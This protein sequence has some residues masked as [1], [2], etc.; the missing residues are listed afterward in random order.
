MPDY[1][2]YLLNDENHITAVRE[3]A[4]V[5]D[6]AALAHAADVVG[7]HAGA[8]VWQQARQVGYVPPRPA[9]DV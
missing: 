3:T 5:D 1:R 8:E 6:D 2:V 7:D 4:C 9:P